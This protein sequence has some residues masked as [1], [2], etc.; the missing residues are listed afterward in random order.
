MRIDISDI[1]KVDGASLE[2]SFEGQ[3]EEFENTVGEI[4]FD[5][6]VNFEGS[7]TNQGGILKLAG[8]LKTSYSTKCYRCL[9]ELAREVEVRVKEDFVS[10][11]KKENLADAYTYEGN[12]IIIDKALKDNIILNLPMKQL[13]SEKCKGLCHR[14]GTNLNERNCDCKE[15][16]INPK[17]EVLKNYFKGQDTN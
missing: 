13:C 16:F 17:L 11:D 12:Y 3:L 10:S 9:E 6:P 14:C 7:L 2:V 4:T 15:D 1:T 8:T 5:Q